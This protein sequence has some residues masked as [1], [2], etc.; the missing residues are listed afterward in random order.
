MLRT[1]VSQAGVVR[2]AIERGARDLRGDRRRQE[3]LAE[4]GEVVLELV[5][6]GEIDLDE[7]PAARAI[8]D[9]LDELDRDGS[10]AP[11][12][13]AV[14]PRSRR[15][16]D[17]RPATPDDGT[18]ASA[19]WRPPNRR[20]QKETTVWRPQVEAAPPAAAK[21]PRDP[22]RKGGIQFAEDPDDEA[23]LAD[24][25]HPDDVPAKEETK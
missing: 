4:L 20:A 1:A 18:V 23:D 6:N 9:H 11:D 25:M 16:F 8:I 21:V 13:A 22:G 7:L 12:T 14:Q 10:P 24:Y 19:T 17:D 5:R 3:A 2:D 15:R